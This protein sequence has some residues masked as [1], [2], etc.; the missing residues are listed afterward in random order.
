MAAEGGWANPLQYS[1]EQW[2]ADA[3]L[4]YLRAR[5]YDPATG[6]FLTRDPFPGFAALTQSQ[7]PYAYAMNNPVLFVDP[8][9]QV[10][11]IPAILAI[12][13]GLGGLANLAVYFLNT[14]GCARTWQGAL[15]AFGKG[16]VAGLFGTGATMAMAA[17]LPA[18]GIPLTPVWIGAISGGFGGAVSTGTINVLE[19]RPWYSGLIEGTVVGGISGGIAAMYTPIRPGPA[20]RLSWT[21]G[22][23]LSNAYVGPKSIDMVIEEIAQDTIGAAMA[24]VF[25]QESPSQIELLPPDLE[26]YWAA[27]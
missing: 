6:R 1:G 15:T 18:I 8:S 4:L 14:P 17:F 21:Q 26:L 25:G 23:P 11:W 24:I 16:A 27:P 9:G 20:P 5:W 2:D 12:G 3:G 19:R 22:W 10:V 13:T 7:N